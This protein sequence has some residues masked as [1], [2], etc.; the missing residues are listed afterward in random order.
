MKYRGPFICSVHMQHKHVVHVHGLKRHAYC[1]VLQLRCMPDLEVA[2]L[3][4]GVARFANS[5]P[6]LQAP[7]GFLLYHA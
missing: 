5:S 7:A 4:G 2:V 6:P 1:G 3:G